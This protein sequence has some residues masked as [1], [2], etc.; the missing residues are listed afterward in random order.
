MGSWRNMWLWPKF[1]FR[2]K[3][4]CLPVSVALARKPASSSKPKSPDLIS[5][6]RGLNQPYWPPDLGVRT[7]LRSSAETVRLLIAEPSLHLH[8]SK[9]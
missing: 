7:N 2:L 3:S 5:Y 8:I 1:K 9:F 6:D 4:F